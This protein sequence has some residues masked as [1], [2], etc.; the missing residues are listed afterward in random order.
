[1]RSNGQMRSEPTTTP[2]R[3][4]VALVA[5]ALVL[6]AASVGL[7]A[8]TAHGSPATPAAHVR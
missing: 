8:V 1:M 5:C 6:G 7:D 3:R 2:V 4:V